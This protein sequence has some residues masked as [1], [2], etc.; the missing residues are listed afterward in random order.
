M[1]DKMYDVAI[2]GGGPGGYGA[3]LYAANAGLSV[4][5]IEK[6]RPGGT[7][8]HRGC[9]PAKALLETAHV[10]RTIA[11]AAEFGISAEKGP[12][13]FGQAQKRKQGIVEQLTRGLAGLLKQRRVDLIPGVGYL[14]ADRTVTVNGQ[15]TI[16]AKHI[17]LAA[18]SKPRALDLCPVDGRRVLSSDEVL[19]LDRLPAS[20]IVIGGGVIGLEFASM[21]VDLGCKV[22]VLEAAP[23]ALPA[24]DADVAAVLVKQLRKRGVEIR[25]GVKL[26]HCEPQSKGVKLSL[27]DGSAEADCVIVAIGRTPATEGLVDPASG[28]KLGS[29]GTISV[30]AKMRT[31]V[32]GVYAVGDLVPTPQLAHVAFAEAMV[33]VKDILGEEPAP[34]DYD[35]VPWCV[36]TAPEVA[37]VGMTESQA[38][39]SG[40]EVV[41]KKE[42]FAGN[43]RAMILGESD[44]LIK[45]IAKR[46]SDGR[47]GAIVGVHMVGPWVTEQLASAY[48]AANW[49]A[50]PDDVAPLVFPHPS[51]SEALGEAYIALT[52]RGL[53]LS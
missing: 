15:E 28:V 45:V 5:L 22:T 1:S 52:G 35:L 40:I 46:A 29:G 43:G 19:S 32:P 7:C 20:A 42:S 6:E 23:Q 48:L 12:I 4:A 38:K 33:A 8:L 25:T 27:E 26:K 41:V 9:I 49:E 50:T 11:H 30:D 16:R 24:L 37:F 17:I 51:L 14:R 18:G 2:V 39:S 36:Y 10:A 47:A 31:G 21:M 44:G 53:H 3:A 34:I 13:D